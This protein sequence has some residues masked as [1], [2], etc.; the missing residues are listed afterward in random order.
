MAAA[1]RERLVPGETADEDRARVKR[2]RME[3]PGL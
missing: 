1:M 3:I 2:G